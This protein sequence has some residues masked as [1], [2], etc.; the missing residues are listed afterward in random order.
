MFSLVL[1]IYYYFWPPV[2]VCHLSGALL[3]LPAQSRHYAPDR[4]GTAGIWQQSPIRH[5]PRVVSA[6]FVT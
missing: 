6:T 5:L 1:L 2:D 4:L 3:C